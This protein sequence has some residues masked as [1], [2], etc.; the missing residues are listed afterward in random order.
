M[1]AW[2]R[3][4]ASIVH[5]LLYALM[6][7]IPVSGWIYSSSTGI[8]VVYLGLF[9]LPD[10]VGKDK[11]LAETLKA[12]HVALN[13]ALAALVFVHVGAAHQAP[14][15]RSRRRPA[16]HAPLPP[17]PLKGPRKCILYARSSRRSPPC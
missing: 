9:P 3:R 2:Q 10:L 1:P 12:V 13:F 6:L 11:A 8:S 4:A 16:A 15:G 17:S 5:G 14:L 7:A